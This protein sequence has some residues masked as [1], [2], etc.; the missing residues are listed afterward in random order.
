MF[1][2]IIVSTALQNYL[3]P[4]QFFRAHALYS[5]HFLSDSTSDTQVNLLA[6]A[7]LE[8]NLTFTNIKHVVRLESDFRQDRSRKSR[9]VRFSTSTLPLR[10]SQRLWL[11]T[12]DEFRVCR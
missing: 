1:V 12:L 4:R 7:N 11:S 8:E 9:P 6:L 3:E 10:L 5:N 2:E